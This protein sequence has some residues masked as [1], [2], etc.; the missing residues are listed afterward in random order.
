MIRSPKTVVFTD[1]KESSP[2]F[3]WK[4]PS[5]ASASAA[6]RAAACGCTSRT[7]GPR[8]AATVAPAV[9]AD[10]ALEALRIE[11]FSSPPELPDVTKPRDSGSSASEQAVQ[12]EGPGP[13]ASAPQ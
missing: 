8:A 11:P 12:G 9:R 6:R 5:R 7:A 2:A 10:E 3:E 13:T 4:R 1:A